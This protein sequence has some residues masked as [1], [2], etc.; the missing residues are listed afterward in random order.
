VYYAIVLREQRRNMRLTL[1]TRRIGILDSIITRTTN[2]EGRKTFFEIL[3]YEWTDYEDFEKKY[4]SERNPVA[5]AKR[6]AT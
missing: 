3:S 1:E 5:A 2:E 6:Y 4:C